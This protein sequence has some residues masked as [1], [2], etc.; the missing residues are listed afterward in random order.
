M[1]LQFA[2]PRLDR[3]ALELA[4]PGVPAAAAV[5]LDLAYHHH[6]AVALAHQFQ[7]HAPVVPCSGRVRDAA[8]GLV[9]EHPEPGGRPAVAAPVGELRHG[10]GHS[11]A[12]LLGPFS[13]ISTGSVPDV[14]TRRGHFSQPPGL[15]QQVGG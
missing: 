5:G 13:A 4:A 3:L 15:L 1:H 7:A 9:V 11:T 2:Y 12:A 6:V 14:E 10:P 8:T